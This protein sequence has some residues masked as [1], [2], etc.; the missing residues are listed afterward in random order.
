MQNWLFVHEFIYWTKERAEA[1]LTS[2]P[3]VSKSNKMLRFSSCVSGYYK[4]G[5][6]IAKLIIGNMI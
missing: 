1:L 6:F 3:N 4:V 2:V 5:C